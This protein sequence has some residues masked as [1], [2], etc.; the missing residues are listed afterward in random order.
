MQL[1]AGGAADYPNVFERNLVRLALLVQ[2]NGLKIKHWIE[3]LKS[4]FDINFLFLA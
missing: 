3:F 1:G 2:T 4:M